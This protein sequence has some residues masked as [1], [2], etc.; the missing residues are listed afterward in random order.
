MRYGVVTSRLV[1]SLVKKYIY[2]TLEGGRIFIW[3]NQQTGTRQNK[4]PLKSAR[5]ELE[6]HKR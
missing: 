4:L 5:A 6:L 2:D 1:V 3:R